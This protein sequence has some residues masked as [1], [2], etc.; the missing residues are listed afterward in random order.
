M[1]LPDARGPSA[2]PHQ[3]TFSFSSGIGIREPAHRQVTSRVFFSLMTLLFLV[4]SIAEPDS[5]LF[6]IHTLESFAS[7]TSRSIMAVSAILALADVV[8]N[9]ILSE[10]YHFFCNR[11]QRYIIWCVLSMSFISYSLL[12]AK[13]GYSGWTSSM[14]V[15]L[16][17]WA[18]T[19]AVMDVVY[20]VKE[21]FKGVAQ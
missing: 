19:I 3:I 7:V 2:Q 15:L 18:A 5:L 9:D 4:I 21:G 8:L 20:E 12:F 11:R 6:K 1:R 16:G 13:L 10:K 14:Y 17:A